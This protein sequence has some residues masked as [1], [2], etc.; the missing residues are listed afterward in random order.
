MKRN[1]TIL[2]WLGGAAALLALLGMGAQPAP[3][4][5]PEKEGETQSL[6]R[7]TFDS[8]TGGWMALGPSGKASV[9]TDAAHVKEGKGALEFTYTVGKAGEANAGGPPVDILLRPTPDG[10][11]AKMRSLRFWA[12]ADADTP[13]VV[14]L[15]E[16]EG[17]HYNTIVW[18]PKDTWQQVLLSPEDFWLGDGKD[19]PKDPDGK[20]DL[21]KVENVGL[22]NVW[23]FLALGASDNPQIAPIFAPHLGAH[24]LWLDDFTASP[25]PRPEEAAP[26]G[27]K[28]GVR[29]DDL[30]R[31]P[32]LGWL[33][34]GEIQMKLDKSDTPIKGTALRLEY[35]QEPGKFA[36]L[37][38]DLHRYNLS[39]ASTL[40]LEV[41]SQ[42]Q[43]KL[44]VQLEEKGGAKYN[45]QVDVPAG[46]APTR[47]SVAFTDFTL[48]DDSPKDSN[49]HLDLDQIK[50]LVIVDITSLLGGASQQ[51]TL[52]IGPVHAGATAP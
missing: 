28:E 23:A 48:A 45:A 22:V 46:A 16:K 41:A 31:T 8:E 11:L 4:Q 7:D 17:G 35:P 12:R 50:S 9:T 6:F 26:A 39:K 19:D 42:Q 51:N 21:D 5:S 34:I 20:L 32:L 30:G 47:K 36:A 43:A 15:S 18:L 37:M 38:H 25:T 27:D 44:I 33:P 10:A 52:W 1:T 49:D 3:A 2:A 14:T 24:S 40:T 29:I 13:L